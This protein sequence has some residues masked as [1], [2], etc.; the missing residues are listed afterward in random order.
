MRKINYNV[1]II[2][3]PSGEGERGVLL[4]ATHK[5]VNNMTPY[6]HRAGVLPSNYT[7]SFTMIEYLH[8]Q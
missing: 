4:T 5:H 1:F 2:Y 8:I 6:G 7:A 3:S